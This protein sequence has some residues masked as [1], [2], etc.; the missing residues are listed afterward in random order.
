MTRFRK[1]LRAAIILAT[2]AIGVWG[3]KEAIHST[4]HIRWGLMDPWFII[5][6]LFASAS[7]ECVGTASAQTSLAAFRHR[8]TFARML[9]ITTV[10]TATNSV[11]P[12]PAGIPARIWL[13]KSWLGIP[14]SCST[15]AIAL[16][17]L[18]GY[19]M[20]TLFALAGTFWF[21]GNTFALGLRYL[22]V[23]VVTAALVLLMAWLFRRTLQTWIRQLIA[24]R[25][26]LL[27]TY[28][29]IGLNVLVIALATL[30]LWLILHAMGD[31]AASIAQITAALCIARVAGVASMIPMGLGSRDITLAGLLV[32]SGVALP[33]AALAAAVDRVLSTAPYLTVALIG[34]P[35]LRRPSAINNHGDTAQ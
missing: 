4:P 33:I 25:P 28:G 2:I 5:A 15:A 7:Q 21:G 31:G 16:E 32:V 27:P 9:I 12:V 6:A 18:C 17:M 20:L 24:L 1:M 23:F 10:A 19:G 26:A 13:Q 35:L 34:W 22:P 11:I 3:I 14:V 29:I 8:A 30:R